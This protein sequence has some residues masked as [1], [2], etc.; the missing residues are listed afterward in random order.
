MYCILFYDQPIFHFV[1]M[2]SK[3]KLHN[4]I[5]SI[6]LYQKKSDAYPLVN[7]LVK[8]SN[9]LQKKPPKS[10]LIWVSIEFLS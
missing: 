7:F 2:L 6:S 5:F 8:V 4:K 9:I 3:K 10:Y 1:E